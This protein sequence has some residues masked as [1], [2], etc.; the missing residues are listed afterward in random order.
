MKKIGLFSILLFGLLISNN[1]SALELTHGS[2]QSFSSGYI[3]INTGSSRYQ[4][5]CTVSDPDLGCSGVPVVYPVTQFHLSLSN[6]IPAGSIFTFNV[7]YRSISSQG[8][9]FPT[10]EYHGISSGSAWTLLDQSCTTPSSNGLFNG[11]S[12]GGNLIY[13]SNLQC[14]YVGFT[15]VDL[16]HIN[17]LLDAKIIR[18]KNTNVTP[19]TDSYMSFSAVSTR[20]I[21]WNGLTAND[22]AWLEEHMPEGS[23]TSDIESAIESAREDEK[24]EYEDQQEDVDGGADDAGEEAEEATSSLID[25]GRSIIETIRDTPATNCVIRIKSGAFDTGNMNLCN[26]PQQIRTVIST[27]ITIPVTLAALHIAYST[28][29]LYLNTVRKEQE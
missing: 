2:T 18:F 25:T 13:E 22:R 29:M 7:Y 23:S 26:V 12:S 6:D 27:I 10:M 24:S 20:L 16:D 14:T 17:T 15:N 1:A 19:S 21:N 9:N 3:N 8:S 4:I 5:N 11:F 28:V